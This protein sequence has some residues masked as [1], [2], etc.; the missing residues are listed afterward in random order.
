MFQSD[1]YCFTNQSVNV[2]I[3]N[4]DKYDNDYIFYLLKISLPKVENANPGTASGRDHVSK[5]SFCA[6][7][8][9][10]PESKITQQ[11]IARI[12][13]AYD[14]LIENNLKR[15][16]LMEE[17]AQITY[18]EWFVR[19]KF[20]GH[21]I[22][23][24][25]PETDLPE[26]WEYKKL[27]TLCDVTSSKRVFLSDY[28]EEGIPFYRGKEI[29]LKSKNSPLNDA[30]YISMDKYKE[31]DE[32]FGTPKSGDILITAVGTLGYTFLVSDSDER[33]Y[34]KDGNLIWLRDFSIHFSPTYFF[35]MTKNRCFKGQLSGIT[36]GSSQKAL[37]IKGI[38]GLNI[39]IP[40]KQIMDSYDK[41][42][43]PLLK[44]IKKL[45]VQNQLL[46][47]ARDILLPRLMT[48]LIDVDSLELLEP[49]PDTEAA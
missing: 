40:E 22:T 36:I 6:I 13:S 25:V 15:I 27:S 38:K 21:E 44:L 28:V 17:M 4:E 45:L 37:T 30:L 31:I 39:L 34:F 49:L 19:M 32:K 33:F 20:P 7:K 35:C 26:R 8:I 10:V 41:I 47:E 43:I 1:Q 9:T 42:S 48:G 16:K 24:I 11:K 14:D 12:L 46:K 2:V 29:I 5:S 18:E 3:P 23:P